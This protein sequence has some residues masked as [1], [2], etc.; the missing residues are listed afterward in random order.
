[1]PRRP[2]SEE[3]ADGDREDSLDGAAGTPLP[4]RNGEIMLE[5]VETS[6]SP[7]SE[8]FLD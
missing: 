2:L 3:R 8:E 4:E 1:M 7:N 5:R 6:L